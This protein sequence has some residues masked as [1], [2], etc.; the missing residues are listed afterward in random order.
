MLYRY[1]EECEKACLNTGYNSDSTIENNNVIGKSG[2][3]LGGKI[4]DNGIGTGTGT[5]EQISTTS[6]AF[7]KS[8]A[9]TSSQR[10]AFAVQKNTSHK[11]L[12]GM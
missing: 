9:T 11:L 8:D 7:S 5:D 6:E 1:K 12:T 4:T 10:T 3:S 2:S